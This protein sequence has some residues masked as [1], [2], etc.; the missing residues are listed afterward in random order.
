MRYFI[1]K[2]HFDMYC[3]WF[4]ENLLAVD[5]LTGIMYIIDEKRL[6]LG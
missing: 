5:D 1:S 3:F 4:D 2:S 6:I